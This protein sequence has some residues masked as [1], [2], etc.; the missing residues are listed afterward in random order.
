MGGLSDEQILSNVSLDASLEDLVHDSVP[1]GMHH[2]LGN[3]LRELAE[4]SAKVLG[5]LWVLRGCSASG[6]GTIHIMFLS[7]GP[8]FSFR[9][10]NAGSAERQF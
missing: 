2:N 3:M 8:S 4:H 10:Q 5:V 7:R 6:E 1:Y 9:I